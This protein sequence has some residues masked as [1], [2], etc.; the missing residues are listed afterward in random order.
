M[1]IDKLTIRNFN[2]FDLREFQFD[3]HF[4]LLVGDNG[5]GKTTVLDALSVAI[6]SWFLGVRGYAQ[7]VGI[8]KDEVRVVAYP[9]KDRFTFEPQFPTR[10]EA[11]G[12]VMGKKLSW[13]RE[14][15]RAGGHTTTIGARALSETAQEAER[16]VQAGKHITLPLLCSFGTERLWFETQHKK[17]SRANSISHSK[18]SRLN[19]YKDCL[20]F[21]I[22]ES[23]L[24]EWIR[25]EVSVGEQLREETIA[26]GVVRSAI[27][28]CLEGAKHLYYDPRYKDLVIDIEQHGAQLFRNLSDGQ[29]IMLTLVGDL[30][31]RATMLNP[32]L[33]ERALEETP[34]IVLIDELDLHL[35]PKWQ[36]HVIYDLKRTFPSLQFIVTSHSPQLIGEA[37]PEEIQLLD[38]NPVAK[39]LR[40]FGIDSSRILEEL[41]HA[42]SRN[43]EVGSLLSQL[44]IFIDNENF[45]GARKVLIELEEKLGPDDPEITRAQSLMTFLESAS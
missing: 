42:S 26:L 37:K 7:A 16:A 8:D 35:H 6:G 20:Y 17:S 33:E 22:Q 13:A 45:D 3:P 14:M 38:C 43:S 18:P 36:R 41:M 23:A 31:R 32:H 4:N 28:N 9:Y 44:S 2:G 21:E 34:G 15:G 30:A 25:D 11:L 19:G 39:P 40:S 10:V 29:R 5:T 27:T 1:R 24:L 12:Q